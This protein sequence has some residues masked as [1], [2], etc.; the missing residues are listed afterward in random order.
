MT[1]FRSESVRTGIIGCVKPCIP[2][3]RPLSFVSPVRNLCSKKS[4]NHITTMKKEQGKATKGKTKLDKQPAKSQGQNGISCEKVTTEKEQQ[5]TEG[6]TQKEW[7]KRRKNRKTASH[8]AMKSSHR[9]H[10]HIS[11]PHLSTPS[12]SPCTHW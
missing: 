7:K 12:P 10:P 11:H 6:K 8:D 3:L 2:L 5:E 4:I 9:P 1:L